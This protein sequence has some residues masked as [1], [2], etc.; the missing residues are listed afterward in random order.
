MKIKKLIEEL[1]K[2]KNVCGNIEVDI[3]DETNGNYLEIKNMGTTDANEEEMI[4]DYLT[5]Y[6]EI[7]N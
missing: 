6:T 5:I 4:S 3:F 7:Q 2:I 1:E